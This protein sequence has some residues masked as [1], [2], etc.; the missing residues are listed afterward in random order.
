V[1]VSPE[2]TNRGEGSAASDDPLAGLPPDLVALIRDLSIILPQE[3]AVEA[4][5]AMR[6]IR[7]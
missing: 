3:L 6:K 1:T 7:K 4:D 2:G 5:R